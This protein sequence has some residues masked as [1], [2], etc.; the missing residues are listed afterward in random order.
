MTDV[1]IA[2]E[3][4]MGQAER[5]RAWGDK[6]VASAVDEIAGAL[7]VAEDG[8]LDK[9]ERCLLSALAHLG[10]AR[11]ARARAEAQEAIAHN[12]LAEE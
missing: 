8:C 4:I 5:E 10:K 12:L 2:A 9:A 3:E 11:T 1:R 6:E 7:A